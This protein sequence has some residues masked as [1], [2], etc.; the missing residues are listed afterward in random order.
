MFL[1]SLLRLR[2]WQM[3]HDHSQKGRKGNLGSCSTPASILRRPPG[4]SGRTNLSVLITA[5]DQSLVSSHHFRAK[6]LSPDCISLISDNMLK[7]KRASL[8]SRFLLK[9]M[10][11]AVC[12]ERKV[13]EDFQKEIFFHA[14]ACRWQHLK[15]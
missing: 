9:F 13:A 11:F 7:V 5:T 2:G 3:C 15:G 1:V 6:I 8:P 10:N 12:L 4:R 14:S